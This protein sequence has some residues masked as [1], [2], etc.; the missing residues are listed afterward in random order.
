[1]RKTIDSIVNQNDFDENCEI[2]IS[3]NNSTDNT[4]E[5]VRGFLDKYYNISYYRNQTNIGAERNILRLIDI[6]RGDF[7]K[8]HSDNRYFYSGALKEIKNVI[9]EYNDSGII[10]ILNNNSDRIIQCNS[11]DKFVRTVSFHSTWLSG[12]IIKNEELKKIEKKDNAVGSNL[13][14]TYILFKVLSNNKN[15]VVIDKELLYEEELDRKGGYNL[16]DVFI[17]HY[18]SFYT[19]YLEKGLLSKKTYETEKNRL[20]KYF[21]FPRYTKIILMKKKYYF[22]MNNAYR[23]IFKHYGKSLCLYFYP[24]ILAQLVI[25]KIKLIIK[26]L[27]LSH[28][29]Q[30]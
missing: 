17:N 16:F 4:Q 11:F 29:N 24:F 21:V 12:I 25:R 22:D 28:Q 1:M 9:N 27:Y 19:E 6:A 2:I 30:K 15:S 7:L 14:Q 18:L 26:K 20:L 13:S 3:D 10:F 23:I 5:V 8:L